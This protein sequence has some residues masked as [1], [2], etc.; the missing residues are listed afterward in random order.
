MKIFTVRYEKHPKKS[1]LESMKR[2]ISTGVPDIKGDELICDSMEAMLKAMKASIAVSH[3]L[4]CKAALQS[5]LRRERIRSPI[6]V[7]AAKNKRSIRLPSVASAPPPGSGMPHIS[8]QIPTGRLATTMYQSD[9]QNKPL[10]SPM[11]R[12]R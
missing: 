1:I 5:N 12:L 2:A 7:R 11:S 4:S 8:S 6:T 9:G 10:V 3:G